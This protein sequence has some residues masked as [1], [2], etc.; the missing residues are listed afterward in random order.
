VVEA[1]SEAG[2]RVQAI[3]R[4]HETLYPSS[5][6]A[7]LHF[8]E[9]LRHLTN[10][11]QRLQGR[12]EITVQVFTDD[13]VL[14]MDTAIPLGLIANE[15]ILNCLKHAFPAGREGRVTVSVQY[16]RDSV[17]IGESLDRAVIR[18]RVEDNGI[19]LPPGLDIDRTDSLGW[20]LVQLLARQ[21]HAEVQAQTGTG[22][23]WTVTVPPPAP[24]P[25]RV[26]SHS[27]KGLHSDRGR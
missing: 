5:N 11:L 12:A 22:L 13:I 17:G 19:G 10:E 27:G 20:R 18:L 26:E 14:G 4:L 25:E 2:S 9:Y 1:L 23:T 7:E 15:L 24:S 21:L 6:L 3:A 8:G 16:G